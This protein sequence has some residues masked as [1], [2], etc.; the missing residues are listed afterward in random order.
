MDH[1]VK[2]LTEKEFIYF[3]DFLRRFSIV[4]HEIKYQDIKYFISSTKELEY[5]YYRRYENTKK[6]YLKS[7]L[8]TLTEN[9]K[10]THFKEIMVCFMTINNSR[11]ILFMDKNMTTFLGKIIKENDFTNL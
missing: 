10:N 6:S 8:K 3:S 1:S 11:V 4:N 5:I 2:F 9:L 7:E